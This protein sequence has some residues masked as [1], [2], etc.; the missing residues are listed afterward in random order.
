[1]VDGTHR[2]AILARRDI[3]DGE[4]LFY[5]Y[6]YDTRVAPSWAI[7]GRQKSQAPDGSDPE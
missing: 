1:M 3:S 2:V 5:D 4:E 7:E 6:N